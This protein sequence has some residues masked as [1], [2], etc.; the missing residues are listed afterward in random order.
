MMKKKDFWKYS[1]VPFL[2]AIWVAISVWLSIH[3]NNWTWFARS[4]AIMVFAGAV[5]EYYL[6]GTKNIKVGENGK[7]I[8]VQDGV[9]NGWMGLIHKPRFYFVFLIIGRIYLIAGTVI[10]AYGDLINDIL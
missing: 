3:F 7:T 6:Q 1:L 4:G 9:V 5:L 8:T 2:T 10:W